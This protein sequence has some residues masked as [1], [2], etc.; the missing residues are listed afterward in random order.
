MRRFDPPPLRNTTYTHRPG[1]YGVIAE[2][3]RLLLTRDA[4]HDLQLPGGG[5]DPG[6]G[7]LAALH[8]EVLEETGHRI[9]VVRRLGV[10]QRFVWMPEYTM[11]ARKIC[12]IYLCRSGPRHGPPHEAGH[13]AV[14]M[15]PEEAVARLGNDGDAFFAGQAM[16]LDISL[17]AFRK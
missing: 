8:R 3:A 6:E 15:T 9:Q 17:L 10:F 4:E 12:H 13:E 5:I 7:P 1:A 2:G 16:G 11:F 14:W